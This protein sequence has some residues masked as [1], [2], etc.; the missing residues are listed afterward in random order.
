[1]VSGLSVGS[2]TAALDMKAEL[3]VEWLMGEDGGVQVSKRGL[4]VC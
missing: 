4:A 2:E 3:L 1:M